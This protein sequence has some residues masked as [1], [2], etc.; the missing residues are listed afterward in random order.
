MESAASWI[1]REQC[2]HIENPV[3]WYFLK[4]FERLLDI[5]CKPAEVVII[6]GRDKCETNLTDAPPA[7]SCVTKDELSKRDHEILDITWY[8]LYFS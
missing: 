3:W 5:N 4:A 6:I 2:G 8:F 7:Q 1:L